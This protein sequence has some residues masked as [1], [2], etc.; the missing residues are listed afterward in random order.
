MIRADEEAFVSGEEK[1]YL[2]EQM[3]VALIRSGLRV[4]RSEKLSHKGRARKH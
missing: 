4:N 1:K 3:A 2:E